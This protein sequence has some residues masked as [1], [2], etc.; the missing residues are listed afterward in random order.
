MKPV[1]KNLA[2]ACLALC[3]HAGASAQLVVAAPI[4]DTLSTMNQA[5]TIAKWVEQIAEMK[6][7]YDQLKQQYDAVTGSYGRGQIGLSDSINASSVVPGSWQEVV[8]LQSKGSYGT[9]QDQYE[10][11]LK[12]MPQELFQ[13]PQGQTATS[14]KLST[15]SVRA[16][17]S[18]GD[19]LYGQVQTHLN[20]LAKLSQQVDSTSNVKDAQDLQNRIATENG[21]LQSAMG[22]LGAMNLNLQANALN[23]Q[24]QATAE[25]NRFFRN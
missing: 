20:N 24:N 2:L 19:A 13:N 12:T 3:M 9:K 18:G 4:S 15:D 7:Q 6:R 10:Q 14:Y 16:A 11:L 23:Q 25:N 22:K 1:T 21:M 5:E 17:M 8:A